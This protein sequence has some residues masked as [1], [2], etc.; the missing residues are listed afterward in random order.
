MFGSKCYILKNN[1]KNVGKFE[2]KAFE[3]IFLRYSLE[4]KAY[5]VYVID[6][7]KVMESMN[8]TFDDNNYPGTNDIE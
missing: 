8:V 1:S 2:S 6:H 5:R 3:A 4:M 7:Q